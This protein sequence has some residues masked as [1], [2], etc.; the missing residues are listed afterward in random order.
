MAIDERRITENARTF[1]GEE[2]AEPLVN[3]LNLSEDEEARDRIR[4]LVHAFL[5]AL[6]YGAS[7]QSTFVVMWTVRSPRKRTSTRR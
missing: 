6:F 7:M 2:A 1:Q 4:E 3:W 5:E